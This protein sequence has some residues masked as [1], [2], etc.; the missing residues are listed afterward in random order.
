MRELRHILF[1]SRLEPHTLRELSDYFDQQAREVRLMADQAQRS[2]QR[3]AELSSRLAAWRAEQKPARRERDLRIMRLAR[4]G[5]SDDEIGGQ[6]GCSGRTV[7][8]V[9]ARELGR[10]KNNRHAR[11]DLE[12]GP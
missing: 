4:R 12:R 1:N 6:V 5:L 7:R 2:L 11:G 10:D 8:R 9:V 3:A